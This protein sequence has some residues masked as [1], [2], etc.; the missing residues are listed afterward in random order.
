MEVKSSEERIENFRHL[1]SDERVE[2]CDEAG[3]DILAIVES[4]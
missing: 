1:T 3:R 2:I 4:V